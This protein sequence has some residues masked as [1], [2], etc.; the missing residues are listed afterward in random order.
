[1][2][3]VLLT[4]CVLVLVTVSGDIGMARGQSSPGSLTSAEA[5]SHVTEVATVCGLVSSYR[6]NDEGTE[7]NLDTVAGRSEFRIVI[8]KGQRSRF[9]TRLEDRVAE[10]R[11][12]A[13]GRIDATPVGHQIVV[14]EAARLS[15]ENGAPMPPP[16]FAPDAYCVCDADV[17][18]P[19]VRRSVK[20]RY[21]GQ[22]LAAGVQG[23]V[24]LE[25]VVEANGS[26]GATRVVQSLD[27][28]LD[29]EATAALRQWRFEPARH[30]GRAVP[31][32][33]SVDLS[34]TILP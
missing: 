8:P 1:M 23:I 34:F 27:S 30:N 16:A 12:C 14:T 18:T 32:I 19:K 10:R 15:L 7:L 5:K 29:R 13:T 2:R 11:V 17:T 3:N 25:A 22:R 33:V 26:I 24:R 21:T 6:C 9:D 20:P 4:V 28:A 31:M